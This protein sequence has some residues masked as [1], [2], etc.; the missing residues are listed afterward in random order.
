MPILCVTC[1]Q[2][3]PQLRELKGL[4]TKQADTD[5]FIATL[6]KDNTDMK[7]TIR[8]QGVEITK[9]ERQ[10]DALT[11]RLDTQEANEIHS[12]P[13][14]ETYAEI[15]RNPRINTEI[16]SVVRYEV[17]ERAEIEKLRM[18][19]VVA[20]MVE[21]E[22]D[23][24]DS[25]AIKAILEDELDI[26]MDLASTERISSKLYQGKPRE[27]P[28]LLRLKFVTQRSR[29]EVL[30]KAINLRNSEDDNVK[31]HLYVRPDLTERQQKESKNLRDQLKQTR[32]GNPDHR[33]KIHKNKI[34]C[35]S[36]Q[37]RRPEHQ[38]EVPAHQPEVPVDQP[39]EEEEDYS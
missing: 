20:G 2:E 16:S 14:A 35:T 23:E 32:L 25:D 22:S 31:N 3:I 24:A 29:R 28:R 11:K 27:N 39:E 38:P 9:H 7:E 1:K 5:K 8:L 30:T 13:T 6:T 15:L 34:V 19:L 26:T 18:N 37:L 4:K 21:A 17:T 12:A 10:L 36:Q 33:Y